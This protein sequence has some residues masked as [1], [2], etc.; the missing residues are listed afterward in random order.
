MR[1]TAILTSYNRRDK[2]VA[3]LRSY[4]DQEL[5]DDFALDAVLV[6]DGSSDGTPEAVH[7]LERPV[8]VIR[9]TGDL[10]W[11]SGMATAEE[12]ALESLPDYLLWLNDDVVLDRD[13]VK[14]LLDVAQSSEAAVI[15]VGAVR[16]PDTGELTYTGVRR[17][18]FHPLR[19]DAVTPQQPP[20]AVDTFM[21]NVVLI[22][23]AAY[24]AVGPI[25]GDFDHAAADYDY[26]M[27]ARRAGIVNLLAPSTVGT[28]GVDHSSTPWRDPSLPLKKRVGLLFGRK[29]V[30]PRTRARYLRRYGGPFWPI[31][32]CGPYIRFGISLLRPSGWRRR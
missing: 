22:P 15:A 9:G 4:F 30:P 24:T 32:W 10:Y 26:G 19:F 14:R 13:A 20:A 18:R 6:D 8:E 1:I 7:A 25:D 11:S 23:R 17:H 21:G 3:C 29:G 31:F 12:R 5:P 28:C 27:R 2:T 16:D